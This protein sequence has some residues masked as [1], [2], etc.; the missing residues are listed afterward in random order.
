LNT[1][2]GNAKIKQVRLLSADIFMRGFSMRDEFHLN[3]RSR[4]RANVKIPAQYFIKSKS[5]RYE[6]CTIINL[7]R[8]GAAVLFFPNEI[9]RSGGLIFLDIV[10]P[11]TFEQITL[12]GE[13]K[14]VYAKGDMGVAGIKFETMLPEKV[15][16]NLT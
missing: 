3:R 7:S 2:T 5:V 4:D 8:T 14:R 6:S 12:R 11:R 15:F 1:E 9:V 10:I 13:L 16:S